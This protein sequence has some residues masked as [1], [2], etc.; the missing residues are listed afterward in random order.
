MCFQ[1]QNSFDERKAETPIAW[2]FKVE[3]TRSIWVII[4]ELTCGLVKESNFNN[5]QMERG[6][7]LLNMAEKVQ[8]YQILI[9][10]GLFNCSILRFVG[11]IKTKRYCIRSCHE[12]HTSGWKYTLLKQR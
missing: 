10:S 2:H 5:A 4:Y 8:V 12:K 11:S 1:H 9:V 6:G 7:T 3:F